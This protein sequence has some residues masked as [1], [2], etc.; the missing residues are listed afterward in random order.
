M[1][2]VKER[3]FVGAPVIVVSFFVVAG[4]VTALDMNMPE[5]RIESVDPFEFVRTLTDDDKIVLIDLRTP[6]EFNK[7]HLPGSMNV[8]YEASDFEEMLDDLTKRTPYAIYCQGG[9]R[10]REA[11]AIMDEKDFRWVIDLSGGIEAL[12][13]DP[14]A[15]EQLYR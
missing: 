9:R 10:S 5:K 3:R 7:G 14:E 13:L 2:G 6:Q 1:I 11:L 12:S 15:I 4:V 8:D